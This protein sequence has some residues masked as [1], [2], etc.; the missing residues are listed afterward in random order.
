M[1]VERTRSTS[2]A[3]VN[4][5]WSAASRDTVPETNGV[6]IE[7][8]E[9]LAVLPGTSLTMARSSPVKALSIEDY[10]TMGRPMMASLTSS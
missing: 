10:P 9:K 2:C 8:P 7:L 6:A 4:S 5:G 1:T 3:A